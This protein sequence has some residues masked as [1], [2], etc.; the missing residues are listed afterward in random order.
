MP[1]VKKVT[2]KKNRQLEAY[3]DEY[4]NI[5]I[6]FIVMAFLLGAYIL[7]IKPKFD[8]TLIS[9]KDSISQ[10]EQFYLAQK[11]RLVDLKAATALYSQLDE[12]EIEK[13]LAV[14]PN[15]YAK[16]SCLVN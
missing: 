15:E 1:P 5:V 12:E 3:L 2:A 4:F 11:Q 10:Q 16:K 14:L 7:M 9:I 6:V 8:S 13:V